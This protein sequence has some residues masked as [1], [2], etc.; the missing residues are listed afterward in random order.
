[1]AIHVKKIP[2]SK[3]E[4]GVIKL[5]R[6]NEMVNNYNPIMMTAIRSNH[7][8]KFIPSGKDGYNIAFYVTDYATKSQLST[9]QIVPL[10]SS[11]KKKVDQSNANDNALVR[12]KAL[13]TKCLNRITTET[14]ISASHVCHFLLD[15]LDK[16][17]SHVFTQLNLHSALC[18]LA[19]EIKKFENNND[20]TNDDQVDNDASKDD[21]IAVDDDENESDDEESKNETNMHYSIHLGNEGYI[22]V[23]QMIDYIHRGKELWP[24]CLYEYCSKVYKTKITDDEKRK[25]AKR[26]DKNP[27]NLGRTVQP[28]HSFTD[29]HPQSETHWQVVRTEGYELVPSLTM[30]PKSI[31]SDK[32]KFQKC[33]LLLFKPFTCLTDVFDG[34]S[35]DDSYENTDFADYT[36]YI[37]NIQEMHIGLQERED[38]NNVDE[39][40]VDNDDLLQVSDDEMDTDV[41]DVNVDDIDP[42]TTEALDIIRNT[43]WLEESTTNIPRTHSTFDPNVLPPS[44]KWKKDIAKQNQDKLNNNESDDDDELEDDDMHQR[45]FNDEALDTPDVGLTVEPIDDL[46]YDEI[47]ANIIQRYSLNRKQ[48]VAFETSIKNVIKRKRNEETQQLIGYVGGPGGTGKSQVIKAIVAFHKEIKS[49]HQ[50]KLSAYTGTAAKLIGGSTTA[51]LF[52][53]KTKNVSNLEK[54]FMNVNT[55]IIDEVSMI[56][57][58]QLNK[59]S[60]RLTAAKHANPSL[61]FGGIDIIFFGDFIQF[62]PIKDAPLY[63][64]WKNERVFISKSNSDI[65]KQLG[66]NLWKQVNSVVLLDEQMRVTD[67]EYQELLNRLREGKCTDNDARI[68]N[69]RIVGNST[70]IISNSSDPI[71]APGN[72]LVMETN[73]L[74]ASRH[75]QH[76]QVFVSTALDSV[77]K[78]KLPRELKKLIKNYPSTKTDGLPQELPLFEGMPVSLTKN[79]ATELGLT[80]GTTGII[81][82]IHFNKEESI[83]EEI[84]FHPLKYTPDCIIAE[85]DDITMKPLDGLEPN[86]VPIFPTKGNFGVKIKGN[87]NTININRTHFPLVPLFSCTAH[88]SQGKTLTKAIVDLV[89]QPGKKGEMEINFAYV[90]LSRVRRLQDLTILRPFD[91]SILRAKVNEGC[92]AMMD[93]FK[94]KDLCKDM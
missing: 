24:M 62:P 9:H 77:K 44:N 22:L 87:N 30:L 15:N 69:T 21:E 23:N 42:Q 90:P 68:L 31:E 47:A 1:M 85:L 43:G 74:F 14:E 75:S 4:D 10:V 78:K 80:N 60:N 16:K 48:K 73:R 63:S 91:P 45:E 5:K 12:T 3:V 55:I 67:R 66:I 94:R 19:A 8:I 33:M 49:K 59:I 26:M 52:N 41:I 61:P 56:G 84:G 39:D 88:K 70:D 6:T 28:R 72:Q 86:H 29:E 18:W 57:C 50:L 17:T 53:F 2:E 83:T 71:I 37:D 65:N 82:S 34:T 25:K 7:D 79:I 27:Q 58:R 32:E 89:P 11:S 36:H 81:K 20:N 13:I 92:A 64:G 54:R 46:D 76:K 38:R 40:N 93:E 35:W 51:T